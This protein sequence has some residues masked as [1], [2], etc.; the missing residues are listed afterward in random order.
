[1]SENACCTAAGAKFIRTP[2]P[3]G[4]YLR[5][6]FFSTAFVS[7]VSVVLNYMLKSRE[8]H[9][10]RA[11][12]FDRNHMFSHDFIATYIIIDLFPR[13]QFCSIRLKA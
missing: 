11:R 8:C 7:I 10:I 13:K 5:V 9:G 12:V 6:E 4:V 3:G 2:R 1:M